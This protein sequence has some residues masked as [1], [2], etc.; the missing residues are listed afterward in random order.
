MAEE[1]LTYDGL[2]RELEISIAAARAL[3]KGLKLDRYTA[4]DGKTL[5]LV[6]VA[7]LR[8]EQ[9]AEDSFDDDDEEED[10]APV[11]AHARL[12]AHVDDAPRRRA[13]AIAPR[14]APRSGARGKT[15]AQVFAALYRRI[16]DIQRRLDEAET[17]TEHEALMDPDS[18]LM[19][20]F[21]RIAAEAR[22]TAEKTREE[23]AEYRSR[24]WWKRASA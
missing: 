10:D 9:A 3:A 23:L 18:P 12:R 5:I 21:F 7:L 24:K 22:Q 20:E 4:P 6:D 16:D 19:T 8:A 1:L 13:P 15:R 2:A 14:R 11:R 17:D